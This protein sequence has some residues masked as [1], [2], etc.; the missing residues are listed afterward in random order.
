VS[1]DSTE[2]RLA[3]LDEVLKNA[4]NRLETMTEAYAPT[5]RQVIENGLR[6]ADLREDMVE[7][8]TAV[9]RFEERGEERV[10]QLES[11]VLACA[12]ATGDLETRLRLEAEERE[13]RER[14]ERRIRTRWIVGMV[15]AFA[16]T[17]A[18]VYLGTVLK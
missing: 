16:T 15:V 4:V 9:E 1:P 6:I 13:E 8:R 5:N 7:I 14:I 2:V 3:R 18:A 10:R 11:E 17:I 12:K